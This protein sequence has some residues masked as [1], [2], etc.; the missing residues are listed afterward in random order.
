MARRLGVLMKVLK[1]SEL[2]ALTFDDLALGCLQNTQLDMQMTDIQ[3]RRHRD[4]AFHLSQLF[5]GL[6][7]GASCKFSLKSPC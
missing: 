5:T 6:F 2:S 7:I 4:S 1:P 3:V